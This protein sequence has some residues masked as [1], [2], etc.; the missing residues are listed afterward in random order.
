MSAW[1]RG[2]KWSA[3]AGSMPV[4]VRR[5]RVGWSRKATCRLSRSA[6]R[7]T[8][9]AASLRRPHERVTPQ[10]TRAIPQASASRTASPRSGGGR[11]GGDHDAVQRQGR[12]RRLTGPG[13]D[14]RTNPRRPRRAARRGQAR[15]PAPAPG[16][17]AAAGVPRPRGVGPPADRPTLS[18]A[19]T[20]VCCP[21]GR[22]GWSRL[23]SWSISR[24]TGSG[25]PSICL[26]SSQRRAAVA[27][28]VAEV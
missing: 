5:Q 26:V 12:A 19:R 14:P 15:R 17:P 27:G 20:A 11:S 6:S 9:G 24:Q 16:G 7:R 8:A 21:A 2:P 22:R 18:A 28:S 10:S 4:R 23:R 13:S 1:P 25:R 3:D